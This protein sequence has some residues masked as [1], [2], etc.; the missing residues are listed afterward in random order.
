MLPGPPSHPG[1]GRKTFGS[2]EG[3]CSGRWGRGLVTAL[4][5]PYL[6]SERPKSRCNLNSTYL[7]GSVAL[8]PP[9]SSVG[10]SSGPWSPS[11]HL[12]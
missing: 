3:T 9:P 1:A 2:T 12:P 8:S 7:P 4:H 6:R 11:P 10:P 5:C